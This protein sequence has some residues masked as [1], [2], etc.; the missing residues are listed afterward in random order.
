MNE[1]KEVCYLYGGIYDEKRNACEMSWEQ[2]KRF[3]QDFLIDFTVDKDNQG[4]S[5]ISKKDDKY[6]LENW[7]KPLKSVYGIAGLIEKG[8]KNWELIEFKPISRIER[9][10]IFRE[11]QQHEIEKFETGIQ[12]SIDR[13]YQMQ[14][15]W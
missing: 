7:L 3:R 2:Y 9:N 5:L 15:W 11:V 14:D 6:F 1:L 12:K 13:W 10:K 4:V 8:R